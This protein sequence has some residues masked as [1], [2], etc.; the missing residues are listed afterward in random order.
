MDASQSDEH[1]IKEHVTV[2]LTEHREGIWTVA[3]DLTQGGELAQYT[4]RVPAVPEST[5][6]S[7][8]ASGLA[9]RSTSQR[10]RS[11]HLPCRCRH[12][13]RRR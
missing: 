1:K 4:E 2:Y 8:R 7:V 5:D 9:A 11:V 13:G 12:Q 10:P 3:V 6:R